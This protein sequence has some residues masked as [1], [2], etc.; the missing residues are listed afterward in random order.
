ML[1]IKTTKCTPKGVNTDGKTFQIDKTIAYDIKLLRV[2][3]DMDEEDEEDDEVSDQTI[4]VMVNEEYF[5]KLL[6]YY[7]HY[8]DYFK[9]VSMVNETNYKLPMPHSIV[10][11]YADDDDIR[12]HEEN[13]RQ[14]EDIPTE[15]V[16]LDKMEQFKDMNTKE[17][18]EKSKTE[19]ANEMTMND[20]EKFKKYWMND[21]ERVFVESFHWISPMSSDYPKETDGVLYEMVT[22]TKNDS[23]SGAAIPS[24]K[25]VKLSIFRMYEY[26]GF[27]GYMNTN[28]FGRFL[29]KYI[30]SVVCSHSTMGLCHLTRVE[31]DEKEVHKKEEEIANERNAELDKLFEEKFEEIKEKFYD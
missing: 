25:K 26:C 15:A 21:F 1:T 31:C 8:E 2:M 20:E 14:R 29:S 10:Y 3:C 11:E 7:E 17:L 18:W 23:M 24:T 22:D 6:E 30:N 4:P 27:S 28:S 9:G 13:F 12:E 16:Y 5:A 19:M